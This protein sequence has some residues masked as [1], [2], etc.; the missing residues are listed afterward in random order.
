LVQEESGERFIVENLTKTGPFALNLPAGHYNIIGIMFKDGCDMM[1]DGRIPA[2]FKVEA[3][4]M[5]YL[6]T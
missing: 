6:G 5:N 4:A 3:S 2:T 1:W